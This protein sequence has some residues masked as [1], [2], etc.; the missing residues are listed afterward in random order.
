MHFARRDLPCVACGGAQKVTGAEQAVLV[1]AF[2]GHAPHVITRVFK[3][4]E[5]QVTPFW[6]EA[7]CGVLWENNQVHAWVATLGSLDHGSN[8]LA[9]VQHILQGQGSSTAVV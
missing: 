3:G 6:V 1:S 9:V 7:L 4:F 5:R 2:R 8:A